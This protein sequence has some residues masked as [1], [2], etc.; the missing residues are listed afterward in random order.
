MMKENSSGKT[1][2]T[3]T[4]SLTSIIVSALRTGRE[5]F[6]YWQIGSIWPKKALGCRMLSHCIA[7]RILEMTKDYVS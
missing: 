6:R 1:Y 4:W 7:K 5:S 3:N 2:A